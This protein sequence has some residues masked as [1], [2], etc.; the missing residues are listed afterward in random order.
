MVTVD[1]LPEPIPDGGLLPL[2]RF[3]HVLHHR[4]ERAGG[5][6]VRTVGTDRLKPSEVRTL[7]E[8]LDRRRTMRSDALAE[9]P[10]PS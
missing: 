7:E 2:F 3:F 6:L 5:R 4:V 10:V 8:V 9:R 1:E